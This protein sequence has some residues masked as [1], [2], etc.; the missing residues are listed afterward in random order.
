MALDARWPDRDG[1]ISRMRWGATIY[2]FHYVGDNVY[3]QGTAVSPASGTCTGELV[4]LA[5]LLMRYADAG[6]AA[7]QTEIKEALLSR[8][9]KLSARLQASGVSLVDPR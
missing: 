8:S 4:A 7:Q 1:Y 2:T 9:L 5:E 3:G 6:N